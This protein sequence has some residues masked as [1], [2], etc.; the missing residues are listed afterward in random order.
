MKLRYY[1]DSYKEEEHREVLEKLTGITEEFGIEVEV[2]RIR[3]R[4]G[5]ITGFPGEI[6]ESDI[7]NVYNRD[8][9]YNRTLSS[10]I[11]EPPSSAFKNAKSTRITITGYVGIVED[12]LQWATRLMG[13]PREDYDGDPS[14]YTI[15]FLD[16]V[17]E[18]GESELED[19]IDNE[20]GEDERSVV[21]QF[22]ESNVIEGDVQREVAVGTSIALNEEQSWKAQ[23][24]ARQLSTR[25]VDIVIQ[26]QEYDWV[27]EAKK[28]YNSNSF[29]TVL[30]QV[31]V[32]DA[33]YRQDNNLDENDTKKAV[34][35]GKGPTNI[36][37]QLSMMGFLTGFAK[38]RGV[39]VFISDRE[40]GFIRLT[41]D[42]SVNNQS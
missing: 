20:P 35:F 40:N 1:A 19:K 36:A 32:S 9:S 10:N 3:E 34:V 8:F 39:E 25:N 21:N 31:L 4:H 15:T 18:Y 41:E 6:R 5:A 16:Q 28:A 33:L 30:G 37:G 17:L 29:D 11:G 22:I 2:E 26:G 7:E 23:N 12:G 38:S 42:I 13:T 14:K 24:V 27:I